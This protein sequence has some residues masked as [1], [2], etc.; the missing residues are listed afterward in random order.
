M[1]KL[2]FTATVEIDDDGFSEYRSAAQLAEVAT[3]YGDKHQ[4]FY[5][6]VQGEVTVEDTED[7]T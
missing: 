2:T 5:F 4:D 7:E 3:T 6:A 1:K